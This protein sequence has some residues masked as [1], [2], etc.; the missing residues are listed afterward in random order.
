MGNILC[1][2]LLAVLIVALLLCK[3]IYCDLELRYSHLT[4]EELA[5]FLLKNIDN[6]KSHK[7][8]EML[9]QRNPTDTESIEILH[10]YRNKNK[11]F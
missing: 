3:T 6:K 5:K 10:L 8:F 1:L 11:L 2:L 4:D 9:N 7:L